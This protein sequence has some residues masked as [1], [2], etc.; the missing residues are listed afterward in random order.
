[1][2]TSRTAIIIAILIPSITILTGSDILKAEFFTSFKVD[3]KIIHPEQENIIYVENTGLLQANNVILALYA[4][5]TI[6][7][8][9]DVCP[10]GNM[11]QI[12]DKILVAEFQRMS[13][14]M[15]C[16]FALTVSESVQFDVVAITSDHR[17]TWAPNVLPYSLIVVYLIVAIIFIIEIAVL[18]QFYNWSAKSEFMHS[19]PFRLRR[20]KF[21]GTRYAH[22]TREFVLNEYDLQINEI[23]ATVLELVHGRKKTMNQLRKHSG[24]TMPHVKY[25]IGKLKRLE[26][27][28]DS[29][30][31]DLAL[32]E[33]FK[34]I[35][36]Q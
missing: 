36:K 13:P 16:E 30:E 34:S 35:L 12:D 8:F 17:S 22:K 33:Y 31:L 14:Y 1:M 29:M 20:I 24:L 19:I 27:L 6:D 3:P 23:D 7:N 4:N 5:G 11:Y 32:S 9:R 10:E 26:L 15:V 25:R 21:K 18:I 28:N 2:M